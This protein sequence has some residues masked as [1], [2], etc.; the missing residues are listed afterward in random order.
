M[1][2]EK[3]SVRTRFNIAASTFIFLAT[4][5]LGAT[6]PQA[7]EETTALH[8][9]ASDSITILRDRYG[10]PHI[11]AGGEV[12]A[13]FGLGYVHAQDRLW[14]MEY[15]RRLGA[16]RLSEVPGES[17]L[18]TDKLF[19][20]LGLQHSAERVWTNYKSRE[21]RL[22]NSYVAGINAFIYKRRNHALPPEKS[23]TTI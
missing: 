15:Q 1:S 9:K 18:T 10:V 6:G 11:R 14:Q 22:L 4:A 8:R 13:L 20:T 2:R 3:T 12:G 5:A 17:A 7:A 23:S 19:R 16:G 21:R